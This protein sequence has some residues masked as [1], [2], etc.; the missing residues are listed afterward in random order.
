MPVAQGLILGKG[1]YRTKG[2]LNELKDMQNTK[3]NVCFVK[4]IL[5]KYENN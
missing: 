5:L 3:N 1:E 4:R 2:L